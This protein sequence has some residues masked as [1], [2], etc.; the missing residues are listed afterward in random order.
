MADR[1]VRVY[2]GMEPDVA[3]AP[4]PT[5]PTQAQITFLVRIPRSHT[6]LASPL[7]RPLPLPYQPIWTARIGLSASPDGGR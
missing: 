5:T 6:H 1:D 7:P 4:T 2:A 3:R